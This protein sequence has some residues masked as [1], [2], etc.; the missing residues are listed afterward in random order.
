MWNGLLYKKKSLPSIQFI[1]QLYTPTSSHHQLFIFNT[2]GLHVD[3]LYQRPLIPLNYLPP[4]TFTT[5]SPSRQILVS[6]TF[7]P[8]H[9]FLFTMP[10]KVN[11]SN[12]TLASQS[13]GD[14]TTEVRNL[15]NPVRKPPVIVH[16]KGGQI[17][18][19][20]RPSDWDKQ[21]WK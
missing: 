11:N 1:T 3:A 12:S 21:R 19:E 20:T 13:S 5:F 9:Q 2:V 4:C 7:L 15:T 17:Y 16:N 14:Q 18:D 8:F 6:S 10:H